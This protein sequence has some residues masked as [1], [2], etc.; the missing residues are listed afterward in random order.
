MP[1]RNRSTA[2]FIAVALVAAAG[3]AT[4][5]PTPVATGISAVPAARDEIEAQAGFMPGYFLSQAT[6][7]KPHG[8][9]L[10]QLSLVLEPGDTLGTRGLV[11]GGRMVG[12]DHDLQYEPMLGYRERVSD[13]LALAGVVHGTHARAED[14]G[15]SYEATRVGAELSADLRLGRER[16]WLEP[17]VLA[18]G[19]VTA[20]T[21]DGDYC[22]DQSNRYGVDCA[23]PPERRVSTH[24]TGAYP[25]LTAGVALHVAQHGA[26]VFH[27][28]RV[29]AL[30]S[31]GAM[32]R[33]VGGEQT[34][35]VGFASI[36]LALSIAVGAR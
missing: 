16:R 8:A 18:T 3:C 28:A 19:S 29:L 23:D 35:S 26:S 24:A 7:E 1:N 20:L 5:G 34:D 6:V 36:G 10:G 17:H 22:L 15:A 25:A 30:I 4:L 12:P 11:L 14:R 33:V 21:A 31:G 2:P 27:G 13:G 32:P 9:G